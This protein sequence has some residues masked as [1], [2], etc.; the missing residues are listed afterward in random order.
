MNFLKQ[1]QDLAAAAGSQQPNSGATGGLVG[2]AENLLQSQGGAQGAG[3]PAQGGQQGSGTGTGTG[4]LPGGHQAPT[5]TQLLD[6]TKLLF[7]ATQGQ[8]VD[9]Q[10]LAGAASTILGGL[11]AHGNLDDG[12][13]ATYINQAETYLQDYSG[14]DQ[15]GASAA[16]PAGASATA[17]GA[18]AAPAQGQPGAAAP[19]ATP[20]SN[21]AQGSQQP[22]SGAAPYASA[23]SGAGS[24]TYG[25]GVDQS[26]GYGASGYGAVGGQSGGYGAGG[27]G[28][29]QAGDGSYGSG[30]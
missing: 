2:D 1:A 28:S 26:G 19:A 21:P 8:K 15:S 24:N 13:Y 30:N 11:A 14:Q 3:A 18:A 6:S 27:D 25:S 4:T 29:D 10:Q 20:S 5:N 12:Q 17:P 7:G 22:G 23:P 16:A 9:G